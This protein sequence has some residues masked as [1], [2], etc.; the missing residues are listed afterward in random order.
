MSHL[1]ALVFVWEKYIR[2]LKESDKIRKILV[3]QVTGMFVDVGLKFT[4]A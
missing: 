3:R 1:C 2:K 4:F